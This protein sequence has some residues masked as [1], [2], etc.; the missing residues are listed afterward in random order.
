MFEHVGVNH[1]AT[2]FRKVRDLLT[3]DG[4]AVIHTIGRSEPPTATNPFIAKYIFPGGYIP[5]LSEV[6]AAIERSGLIVTDLEVLRLHYAET[7]RAWRERFLAN[8][9]KRRRASTT[10]RFCRMWEFYLAA[11]ETAFR[12]QN[13]VVFQVQLAKR[14]P[15]AADHA[16][17]HA[18]RP[19][20]PAASTRRWRRGRAWRASSG[21]AVGNR[22]QDPTA[23]CLLPTAQVIRA[24]KRFLV[25]MCKA[26]TR[27]LDER[28]SPTRTRSKQGIGRA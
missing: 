19:S 13:L 10:R 6:A 28:A 11:S 17:L 3:D 25:R 8:W 1:Y 22:Q 15:G 2:Y 12:Y 16:R 4:V 24:P 26:R 23:N 20:T 9:D 27:R 5:A 7:L 14:M 18:P 21:R